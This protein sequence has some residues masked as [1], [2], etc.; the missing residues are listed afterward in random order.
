GSEI[1]TTLWSDI[2]AFYHPDLRNIAGPYDRS[3]GMDMETYV[4]LVGVWMRMLLPA[5]RAPLPVTD[6]HTDHLRDLWFAPCVTALGAK[7]GAAA[8]ARIQRF[9]ASMPFVGRLRTIARRLHGSARR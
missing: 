4:A 3:Y 8:L 1:E 6:A 7:P 9:P 5:D 2:A